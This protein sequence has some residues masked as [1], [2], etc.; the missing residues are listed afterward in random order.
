MICGFFPLDFPSGFPRISRSSAIVKVGLPVTLQCSLPS[1]GNP[2]V[3]WSWHCNGAL[4]TENVRNMGRTTEISFIS[5]RTGEKVCHCRAKSSISRSI[6]SFISR[7]DFE[8]NSSNSY[9]RITGLIWLVYCFKN[10]FAN[11]FQYF[12]FNRFFYQNTYLFLNMYRLNITTSLNM[13]FIH[14]YWKNLHFN[15]ISSY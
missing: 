1:A 12:Y 8:R 7:E 10:N 2:Q 3:T 11:N 15:N 14:V 4:I 5:K 13:Y 9:I 6:I